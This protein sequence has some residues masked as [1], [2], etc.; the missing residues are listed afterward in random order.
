M[1]VSATLLAVMGLASALSAGPA[2][3]ASDLT[4][5][6]DLPVATHE[7]VGVEGMARERV[8]LQ[9]SGSAPQSRDETRVARF[10]TLATRK[11]RAAVAGS[12]VYATGLLI[13]Y[14]LI[15][16]FDR[17]IP[18]DEIGD[19]MAL[20]S[21]MILALGLQTVGV[22]TC[23]KSSLKVRDAYGKY[24]GQEVPKNIS[25]LL[26]YSGLGLLGVSTALSIMSVQ[27]QQEEPS[28]ARTMRRAATV[29]AVAVD[30]TWGAT[31]IYALAYT[32]R[33][34]H[35]VRNTVPEVSLQYD[36]SG[37]YGVTL[38]LGF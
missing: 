2:A 28:S 6:E 8:A 37:R 38:T 11:K 27:V 7:V 31:A 3:V 5:A 29:V 4:V 26:Y 18:G 32:T 10:L 36:G 20:M 17:R 16:P 23:Y 22:K 21:P 24:V 25:K 1:R 12:I 13:N 9:D 33:R 34:L 19:R 14:G 15:M 30:V 35:E